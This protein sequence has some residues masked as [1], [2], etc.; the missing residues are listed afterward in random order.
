MSKQVSIMLA[1]LFATVF[2]PAALADVLQ[3]PDPSAQ[4]EAQAAYTVEM[5]ARGMTKAKVEELF[6]LPSEKIDEV[7][8]PPISNWVYSDFTVYFESDYVIHAVLTKG[9]PAPQ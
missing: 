3:M 4:G 5:P 7:G 1:L 6:G 9:V 2:S 8:S